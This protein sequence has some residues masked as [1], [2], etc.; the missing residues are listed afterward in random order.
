MAT[1]KRYR[2]GG[3]DLDIN[4]VPL[5]WRHWIMTVEIDR[6]VLMGKT[7]ASRN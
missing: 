5:T 2:R 6:Q 7:A 1:A 3:E 4:R